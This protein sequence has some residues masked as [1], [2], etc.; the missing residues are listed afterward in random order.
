MLFEKVKKI[1]VSYF[2]IIRFLSGSWIGTHLLSLP[3]TT[4]LCCTTDIQKKNFFL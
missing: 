2:S 3:S 4:P 1:I